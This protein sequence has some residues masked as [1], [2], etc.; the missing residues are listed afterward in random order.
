M[1][2]GDQYVKW[3]TNKSLSSSWKNKNLQ[4]KLW[5]T[6]KRHTQKENVCSNVVFSIQDEHLDEE[7]K[8]EKERQ[9]T[10]QKVFIMSQGSKTP[11]S[12][13]TEISS[14]PGFWGVREKGTKKN[15]KVFF[16]LNRRRKWLRLVFK[17]GLLRKTRF[18]CEIYFDELSTR[19]N[20]STHKWKISVSRN[21]G[22]WPSWVLV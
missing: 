8:C 15:R 3:K 12:R 10:N 21:S 22:F 2:A 18:V 16:A 7:K 5:L 4:E 13:D 1:G 6:D 14:W 17:F 20:W 9:S 11:R 19:Q